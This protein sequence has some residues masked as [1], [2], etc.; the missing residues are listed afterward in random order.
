MQ[1]HDSRKFAVPRQRYAEVG[2]C[3]FARLDVVAD[4][5]SGIH[6]VDHD[7]LVDHQIQFRLCRFELVA[8]EVEVALA[9]DLL[10][11]L[12]VGVVADAFKKVVPGR[13]ND[14]RVGSLGGKSIWYG[15]A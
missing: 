2:V 11:C 1:G 5:L 7:F 10:S 8:N 12:P 14:R 15:S 3:A 13:K 4:Q 9:Q 6:V